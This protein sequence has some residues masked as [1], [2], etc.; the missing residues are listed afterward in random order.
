MSF[1][2]PQST[3]DWWGGTYRKMP[4]NWSDEKFF[5]NCLSHWHWSFMLMDSSFN[6]AGS[7]PDTQSYKWVLDFFS[8]A[9][10]EK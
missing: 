4:K 5:C 2:Q 3:G 8:G 1:R 6:L 7:I 9:D 10:E